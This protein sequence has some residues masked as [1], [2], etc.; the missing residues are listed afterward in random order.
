MTPA[1]VV[2]LYAIVY[3]ASILIGWFTINPICFR[4]GR[5]YFPNMHWD[6]FLPRFV[7]ALEQFMYTTCLLMGA[8]EFIAVWL[9]LKLAGEWRPLERPTSYAMYNIFLIGNGLSLILSV[10]TFAFI[11][12]FLPPFP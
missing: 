8:K 4:L 12:R 3:I 11:R 1:L 9:V 6:R 5:R 7:G 10:S 2:F